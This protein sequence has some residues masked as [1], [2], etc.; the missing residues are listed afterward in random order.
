MIL[1]Y[2][3]S[4][5]HSKAIVNFYYKKDKNIISDF[6]TTKIQYVVYNLVQCPYMQDT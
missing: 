5:Q 2:S 3:T 1:S 6:K 4:F